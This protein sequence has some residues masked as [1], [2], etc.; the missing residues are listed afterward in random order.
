M[1]IKVHVFIA[2]HMTSVTLLL[3]YFKCGNFCLR[4]QTSIMLGL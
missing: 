4:I 1:Q 3:S 2:N